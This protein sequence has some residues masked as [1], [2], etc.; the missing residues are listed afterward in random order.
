MT[1][2]LNRRQALLGATAISLTA[3]GCGT[4]RPAPLEPSGP[5]R[6]GVASGEPDTTSVVLWTAITEDGGGERGVEV[7]RDADFS[8]IVFEQFDTL[9]YIRMNPV[10]T[11]KILATGLEPG[12][13]YFY[14]FRFNGDHSP[15]GRTRTLPEGE[16]DQYRI[17]VCSCSNFPAGYF[18]AYAELAARDEIDLVLH[19]GDYIYEYGMGGYATDDAED[20]DRVPVPAHECLNYADYAARHAQ[21]KSDPDLQAAHAAA[22]WF[23]TWD[24]HEVANDAWSGGAENHNADTGEGAYSDRRSAG[25]RAFH[26]WNPT[27]EPEDMIGTARRIEIGHLATIALTESRHTARTEQLTFD[28]FPIPADSEDTPENRALVSQWLDEVVGDPSREMLGAAQISEIADLFAS[29]RDAGKPWQV[30]GGQVLLGRV[31]MPNYIDVLPGWLKWLI[32]RRDQLAWDYALRSRFESPFSFDSW[33][34]YPAERERLYAA[35][36]EACGQFI[37]LAGDTHNFWTCDLRDQAGERLG[38]EFGTTSV[39]SPSPFEAIPAP[40][41]HFGRI[42]EANNSEILHHEPYAKGF[43]V[44]TLAPE[45]IETEFVEV[46]T[47]RKRGYTPATESRWR[48]T[49]GAGGMEIEAV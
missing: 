15:V 28:S 25:L 23:I 41:I 5:F 27:R 36:R 14:R 20:L 43:M 19:L 40:G 44:L 2:R 35:L 26:D 34:G 46:S 8:D 1:I 49:R 18:N 38:Y 37:A 10:T 42:T 31:T 29:S 39:T 7:A 22:P 21:Y 17:A 4:S 24:D 11:V 33:D 9:T 6:H 47:I 45:T 13:S 3:T 48:V 30:L 32:R 12:S 16:I